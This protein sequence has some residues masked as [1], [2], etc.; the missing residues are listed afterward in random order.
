M[1]AQSSIALERLFG[2]NERGFRVLSGEKG[3]C[4]DLLPGGWIYG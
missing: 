2:A 1:H 3:E 4:F